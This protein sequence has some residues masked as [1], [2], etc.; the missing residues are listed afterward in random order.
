MWFLLWEMKR[1]RKKSGNPSKVQQKT[2]TGFTISL[3]SIPSEADGLKRIILKGDF[4]FMSMGI[5]ADRWLDVT[6]EQIRELFSKY[7]S[8]IEVVDIDFGDGEIYVTVET[9]ELNGEISKDYRKNLERVYEN[10]ARELNA[11]EWDYYHADLKQI[12]FIFDIEE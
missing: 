8:F 2:I 5:S 7:T 9:H 10:I 11:D 4:H 6:P 3:K 1:L 12:K